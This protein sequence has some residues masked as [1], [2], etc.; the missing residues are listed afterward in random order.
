MTNERSGDGAEPG[1]TLRLAVTG[2]SAQEPQG[3]L[4]TQAGM[5]P[6][7]EVPEGAHLVDYLRV[8]YKRRWAAATAFLLVLVSIT[9]YTFTV[10][11]IYEARTRLLIEADGPNV[12]NFT[13]VLDEQRSKADYYQ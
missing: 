3:G 2:K 7:L 8:L 11:P 1:R 4:A 13:E 6:T 9:I 12:I 10:T 5:A